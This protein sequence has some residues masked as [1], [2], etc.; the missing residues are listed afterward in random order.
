M[1]TLTYTFRNLRNN[2]LNSV[3][4]ICGLS[5]SIFIVLSIVAYGWSESSMD[6]AQ[7]NI[8]RSFVIQTSPGWIFTPAPLK[9]LLNNRIPHIER[10]VQIASAGNDKILQFLDNTPIESNLIYADSG[11]FSIFNYK[12]KDG[13]LQSSLNNPMS[14]VLTEDFAQRIF[15][16][17]TAIGKTLK[18]DDL[19]FLTVT[20]VIHT[21]EISTCLNFDGLISMESRKVI[22]SN[23]EE[24]VNWGWNN[25]QTFILLNESAEV[26]NVI[27]T[28]KKAVPVN[29]K[30]NYGDLNLLPLKDLYF[31]D[32]SMLGDNHIRFGDKKKLKILSLI[33]FIVLS[34]SL[35]NFINITSIGWYNR[36]KQ[37]GIK[38]VIGASHL[39]IIRGIVYESLLL[40]SMSFVI[41][42]IFTILFAIPLEKYFEIIFNPSILFSLKFITSSFGVLILLS[43]TVCLIPAFKIAFSNL[44]SNLK[45]STKKK[46]GII[47]PKGIL[48]I[49]QFSITICLLLFSIL[50][51]RQINFSYNLINRESKNIIGIELNDDLE[52]HKAS[53]KDKLLLNA[54][55]QHAVLS[56]YFPNE[57]IYSWSSDIILEGTEVQLEFNTFSVENGYFDLMNLNLVSGH[58]FKENVTHTKVNE[59]IVNETFTRKYG[60][61]NPVG[62]ILPYDENTKYEIIGVVEDFHYQPSHISIMPLMIRNDE[63]FTHLLVQIDNLQNSTLDE[64]TKD[65]AFLG[66]SIPIKISSFSN[67]ILELYKKDVI[68]KKSFSFFS[69][70]ALIMSCLGIFAMSLFTVRRKTKEIGIRKVNGAS[71]HEILKLLLHEQLKWIIIAFIIACPTSYYIMILWLKDFSFKTPISFWI[72]AVSAF[73]VFLLATLTVSYH[74]QKAASRNPV[75]SLKTE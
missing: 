59:V 34:I 16:N 41:A 6:K 18:F 72:F 43:T 15:G 13:D 70:T 4:N 75:E 26:Q 19:H 36:I 51:Y 35:I 5:F 56:G 38:K 32:I 11:I 9:E 62:T 37:F 28:I 61:S 49:V 55:V 63:S 31:T 25:F 24:L 53:L 29:V 45:N 69:T 20:C 17:E 71:K 42:Y 46:Y 73:V 68:F 7:K 54:H 2:S 21:D 50:V 64:V 66:T 10:T 74:S 39:D 12:V 60:I 67:S 22:K 57:N 65:I 47:A 3:I 58:F 14:I 40:F 33:A 44:N 30:K 27:K 1:K 8:N 23:P 52:P 48:L